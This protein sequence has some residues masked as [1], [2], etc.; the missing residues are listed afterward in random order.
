MAPRVF[1]S[2][3]HDGPE[4]E[5]RVWD[6]AADLQQHGGVDVIIDRNVGA[7]GPEF[8]WEEWMARELRNADIVVVVPSV[9][10]ARK[11]LREQ[12]PGTG[13][14][15]VWEGAFIRHALYATQVRLRRFAV[16]L[17]DPGDRAHLA[18]WLVWPQRYCVARADGSRDVDGLDGLIRHIWDAPKEVLPPVGPRPMLQTLVAAGSVA[19]GTDV[20]VAAA[21]PMATLVNIDRLPHAASTI[22][23]GRGPDFA[24]LDA[25][26]ADPGCGV[27]VLVA[28]G[29]TGKTAL[30]EKWLDSLQTS[31]WPGVRRVFAWSFYS[32]GTGAEA[33]SSDRFFREALAWFGFQGDMP[34]DAIEQQRQLSMLVRKEPSLL[35][36]D[37]VEPLQHP[38]GPYAGKLKD[39]AVAL[40]IK[41]LRSGPGLCLVTTRV[42]VEDV[43]GLAGVRTRDLAM[44]AEADGA[45]LLQQLG[46]EGT[47][48]ERREAS[49]FV[50][51]HALTLMLL[52]HYVR[53]VLGGQA[54]RFREANLA[55]P[56]LPE[57]EHAGKV[58]DAYATWLRNCKRQTE[59]TLLFVL[60]L[61]DRPVAPDVLLAV[62]K[63]P[64]IHGLTD[65]LV[66]VPEPK[67]KQALAHLAD[68]GLLL[69]AERGRGWLA[70]PI[71]AHPLVREH[72]GKRLIEQ[73]EKAWKSAHLRAYQHLKSSAPDRPAT[74]EAMEPLWQAIGHGCKAGRW[75]EVCDEVFERRIRRG[76]QAFAVKKLGAFSADLAAIT[77]F[78]DRPWSELTTALA[79]GDHSWLIN[80]AGFDLLAL[81]RLR[82]AE[83]PMQL[84]FQLS[85][86]AEECTNAA[87]GAD[88]LSGLHLALGAISQAIELA[89]AS[90]RHADSGDEAFERITSRTTCA[91]AL[92]QAG[93]RDEALALFVEAEQ[94]QSTCSPRFPSLVSLQGYQYC[95][96]LLD[97]A[98]ALGWREIGEEALPA[99]LEACENVYLR[100]QHAQATA[101]RSGW[102]LD[103]ALDHL[104]LGRAHLGLSRLAVLDGAIVSESADQ[105]RSDAVTHFDAAV[106]G[107]RRAGQLQFLPRGLLHRAT[108]HGFRDDLLAAQADLDE[109]FDLATQGEMRLHLTD[110]H[111][112]YGWLALA[113]GDPA[114]GRRHALDA[115]RLIEATGYHRRHQELTAL[116]TACLRGG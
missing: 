53:D 94:I 60:G 63:K 76:S 77:E 52:G 50:R 37:G 39:N 96:L 110:A 10:Y 9:G 46:A 20:A 48:A 99:A 31:G 59:A 40:L 73:N 79:S 49:R 14:G 85:V 4:H 86:K 7:R 29:G 74:S 111:L 19:L 87:R 1:V 107:L 113:Q 108:S 64:A 66:S 55:D 75:R 16:A 25:A 112:G 68:L 81:G 100:A 17:V 102:L 11:L 38:P 30:V 104:S 67:I 95:D 116:E 27:C 97:H 12:P 62:L 24:A 18:D 51:G 90:V 56:D 33:T 80:D 103:I 78:F 6:L 22:F 54:R 105:H 15:G 61:F 45:N 47:E 88:N 13:D 106:E 36:L 91:N 3:S 57:A 65:Q 82:E 5:Q 84:A 26:L 8:T 41:S 114:S 58:M 89:Q 109:A 32:Q 69:R 93:K 83:A 101:K 42:K 34:L 35:V 2:Y 23:V 98:M 71:D 92:A 28:P 115:G 43:A 70:A 21:K 44:L 72:F